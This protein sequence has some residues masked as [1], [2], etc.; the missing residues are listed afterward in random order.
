MTLKQIIGTISNLALKH[1][2]INSVY[3][4]NVYECLNANPSNKY[5]S[6]VVTQTT[7]TQDEVF[8]HYGFVIFYVDRL[9][10]D[11]DENRLQIQSIGKTML[12]NIVDAFCYEFDAEHNDITFHPFTQ[13]FVDETAGVYIDIVIDTPKDAVCP[14]FYWNGVKP[15]DSPSITIKNQTKQLQ[16]LENGHYEITYDSSIY[17]GLDKVIIDVEVQGGGDCPDCG[18]LT[19]LVV[20]ENGVYE[21]A[22]NR[23]DVYID[24]TNGSYDDGYNQ[25]YQDGY[26]ESQ[27]NYNKI[28]LEIE[29]DEVNEIYVNYDMSF[30][31]SNGDKAPVSIMR[32]LPN[33]YFW[34]YSDVTNGIAQLRQNAFNDY[35]IIRKAKLNTI[36]TLG[37]RAFKNANN[38]TE[39]DLSN[40]INY[41]ATEAFD[42]CTSLSKIICR[43]TTILLGSNPFNRVPE[44]GTL[45]LPESADEDVWLERLPNGWTV[46]RL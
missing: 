9:V 28:A 26:N 43:A 40:L 39:I 33:N 17:T 44:N 42:G 2:N 15:I 21:G 27:P 46:E 24:D 25:G 18:D 30:V 41:I 37:E 34:S 45:Y 5:A 38:L 4:G 22:F 36:I 13:K 23:V 29:T 1:P 31:T 14:E 10:D 32:D 20:R 12:S 7:H 16:I 8:D 19:E 11:I 6:V 3:E 35:S